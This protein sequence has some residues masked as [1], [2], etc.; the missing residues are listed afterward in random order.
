MS[1][2]ETIESRQ[3]MQRNGCVHRNTI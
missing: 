2:I 1:A 3:R